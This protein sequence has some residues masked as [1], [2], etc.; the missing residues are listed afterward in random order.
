MS[1]AP[2]L[3]AAIAA[4]GRGA[5]VVYPTETFYGLGAAALRP[6][7]VAAV[8]AVKG[9]EE[10]KPIAVIAGDEAML[11]T[12]VGEPPPPA[13]RLMD[14][15]WPGPLTLVLPVRPGLPPELSAGTGTIGVRISAHPVARAL[16][17]ALGEP[18]TATSANPAGAPPP[19]EVARARTYFGAQVSAYVD[20]GTLAG[21]SASTVVSVAADA[22]RL[23]RAGAISI[24]ALR[25]ALG[26]IPLDVPDH[27]G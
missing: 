10:R 12:I 2:A 20:G 19:V 22:V 8:A 21:G 25:R 24:A 4:L 7:A 9:R 11:G 13:R 1:D 5:M 26:P 27:G 23:V 15:F 16:A 3:D 14:R 18:I 17:A 6:A